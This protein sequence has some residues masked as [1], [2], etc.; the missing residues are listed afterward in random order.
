MGYLPP[1]APPYERGYF[2]KNVCP[3]VCP[4]VCPLTFFCIFSHFCKGIKKGAFQPHLFALSGAMICR[5]SLRFSAP[6]K[7][8][9]DGRPCALSRP[10]NTPNFQRFTP[11][12]PSLSHARFDAKIWAF[13]PN[14]WAILRTYSGIFGRTSVN[15]RKTSGFDG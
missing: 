7:L 1:L 4:F 10:S 5:F 15:L 12:C 14:F 3:F 6:R 9:A 2:Y 13:L 8:L 11:F